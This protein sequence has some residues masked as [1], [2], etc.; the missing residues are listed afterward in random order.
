[1]Q[2]A[3]RRIAC[4]TM[5][6]NEADFLPLWVS[7]YGQQA[8]VSNL[9][10]IDDGSTDGSTDIL[11]PNIIKI[12][13][14]PFSDERRANFIGD[15][16]KSLLNYYDVVIYTDAD[17][18][19]IPDPSKY[20]SLNKYCEL[21]EYENATA[22]GLNVYQIP[23]EEP[24]E[25]DWS[26]KI[27]K[28]RRF[29]KFQSAMCKT[30]ITRSPTRWGTG[31]HRS[32]P[33]PRI[34]KDLYL[35]HLKH[36]DQNRSFARQEL[37]RNIQW[38]AVALQLKQGNHQRQSDDWLKTHLAINTRIPAEGPAAF[39]FDTEIEKA[40]AGRNTNVH[41]LET[42]DINVDGPVTILPQRFADC[43]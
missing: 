12:P 3:T 22:V 33:G 30:L 42:V 37:T 43:L 10:V 20:V 34:D 9:F 40:E 23:A 2:V 27:F 26:E 29:V 31:F 28:Q 39:S 24:G 25:L 38:D 1:M 17:E 7:Y 8:G 14:I 16:Q 41:G 11:G 32:A 35:F 15:L 21:L 6:Y 36:V 19:L 18:F 4:I 13:K 5:V